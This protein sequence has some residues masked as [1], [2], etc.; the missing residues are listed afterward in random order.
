MITLDAL[1]AQLL[2]HKKEGVPGNTPVAVCQSGH[3]GH[4]VIAAFELNTELACVARDELEKGLPR[5]LFVGLGD[6]TLVLAI[7]TSS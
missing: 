2:A 4:G 5:C 6:S 1:I 3:H 7:S